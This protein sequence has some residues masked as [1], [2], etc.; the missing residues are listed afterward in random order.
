[1]VFAT[2]LSVLITSVKFCKRSAERRV[3]FL[4]NVCGC[5]GYDGV[6][7]P[8]LETWLDRGYVVREHVPQ[9]FDMAAIA[10]GRLAGQECGR[11]L[12]AREHQ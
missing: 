3:A 4:V 9:P 10:A 1:M 7:W 2:T 11:S 6:L 8:G 5:E 12:K